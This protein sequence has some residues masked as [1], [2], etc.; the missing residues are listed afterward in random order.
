MHKLHRSHPRPQ[1][2]FAISTLAWAVSSGFALGLP[3]GSALA[4]SAAQSQGQEQRYEIAA[5]PLAPALRSAAST[6]RITLTFTP[7]QTDGKTTRGING[8]YTAQQALSE[9]LAGSG[10]EAAQLSNGGY[11]LREQ[12][13]TQLPSVVVTATPSADELP[14]AFA[15]G[16]IARGGRIGLLGNKDVMNTPFA[17]S[18]YTAEYM[19]NQQ[20]T[21]FADV[22]NKDASVRFTGQIGGV[23]DSFYIR[24]FPVGE[25]NLSEVAFDGVYG[26]AP[27]YHIFTQYAERAEVIKGPA[28]LLYGMSPNSGVGGVINIVPKRALAEDLNRVTFD[29]GNG[30]QFGQSIDFSRRFGEDKAWGMRVNALHRD[31]DT[32]LDNQKSTTNLGSI[33]IDYKGE[34]LRSS[35]DLL[36]QDEHVNAPT[37]PFLVAAGIQVPKAADGRRNVTQAWGWWKSYGDSSLFKVEYDVN[38]NVTVFADAG[39]SSTKVSRLSDQTPMLMNSAGDTLST[40]AYYKFKVDRSNYDAGIRAKFDTGAVNHAVTV[41]GTLYADEVAQTN[42]PG[43][44]IASNIYSPIARPVQNIAAPAVIPKVSSTDLSGVAIADTL[45]MYEEKLQLTLGARSQQI[46]S[47]NFNAT[48]ATTSTYDKD[49]VTPLAGLVVKPWQGV[50]LYANAIQGLS[51]GDVAPPAASNAGQ[52]LAPYKTKQKELGAKFDFNTVLATASI[53]EITKPGGALVGGVYGVNSE[54]RNRGLE[55]NLSGQATRSIRLL[56]GLSLIDGELVKTA[57]PATRGKRP[58]GV[59]EIMA[60]IGAEWDVPGVQGFTVNGNVTH[61]GKTYVDQANTQWVPS[62]TTADIGMRYTTKI[63]GRTTTIRGTIFNV[64]DKAYWSG[65]ASF[66]TISQGVPRT[67][68]VSV[69]MDF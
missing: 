47:K 16:Q 58:V 18:N 5:G 9:L 50:S 14:E 68:V 61:T 17:T 49:A 3:S 56:A 67:A 36:I 57:T 26:V 55:L 34:R 35:L 44:A 6:A 19:V 11:V 21:T 25:G 24:G 7:S 29:Y 41:Q 30:A 33:S 32:P 51:K 60:N 1:K 53:F 54:Q 4:Q 59:P 31:G 63:E 13:I 10:L 43:T 28:A 48:G 27:N 8:R 66:S 65:V 23:T 52:V 37:R 42:N 39:G 12:S 64:F 2:A 22:L 45:S 40:P 46:R 62:W 15:G 38:E 69:S 20:A